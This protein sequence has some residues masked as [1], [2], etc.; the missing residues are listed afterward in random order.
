MTRDPADLRS[1][2]AHRRDGPRREGGQLDL[3]AL[4]GH[5]EVQLG[6]AQPGDGQ[7]PRSPR[8]DEADPATRAAQEQVHDDIDYIM[9][10][11]DFSYFQKEVPGFF[12]HLGVGNPKG[13]NHSPLF[14]VDEAAM[15][16]GVR[17][18]ALL[19]LDFL[20]GS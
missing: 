7:Q 3:R 16:T 5:G 18:Q 6:H 17:A 19:A 10:A 13:G 4:W 15:E 9:G 2:H 8:P 14:D 20:K 12:Y 1:G 11:E